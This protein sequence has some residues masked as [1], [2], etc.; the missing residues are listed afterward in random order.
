[1]SEATLEIFDSQGR[2]RTDF[3]DQEIA[4]LTPERQERWGE[5]VA[6]NEAMQTAERKHAEAQAD[7]VAAVRRSQEADDALANARPKITHIEAARAASEAQRTG[8]G[9]PRDPAVEKRLLEAAA[10]ADRASVAVG[11]A[12][13]A[14]TEADT[15]VKRARVAFARALQNWTAELPKLTQKDL[16]AHVATTQAERVLA[17]RALIEAKPQSHLDKVLRATQG[18]RGRSHEH[19]N[20]RMLRALPSVR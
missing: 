5:L 16:I 8:V 20:G 6:T 13:R 1:M 18:K 11:K 17:E 15:E 2:I 14:R 7:I 3:E 4:A 12:H 10:A 19:P 9:T